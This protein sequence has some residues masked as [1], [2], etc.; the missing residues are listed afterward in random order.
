MEV[1]P[2][3]K[4]RFTRTIN[5]KIGN[6]EQ[7]REEILH[8]FNNTFSIYEELFSVIHDDNAYYIKAEP[9]RHP[10]IFYLGHT[11]TFLI[12]KLILGGYLTERVNP[13][14]ESMFAVGVD[15][16]DWDDLNDCHYEWP[17][18]QEVREYREKVQDIIAQKIKNT[19]LILPI[20][21]DS[22]FW[23]IMMGIEHERIHLETSAVIIRRLPIEYVH[24]EGVFPLC[25][26]RLH[27]G[28]NTKD[29][30]NID[31][32]IFPYNQLKKV[33]GGSVV[34]GKDDSYYGWDN[35][36]GRLEEDLVDFKASVFL[37]TNLEF[38]SFV[39][40]GGY[41][42][43][44]YWTQEGWRWNRSTKTKH[45]VFWVSCTSSSGK[46][47]Y[48]YRA[49]TEIVDMPW[50]W[51][52]ETNY[53]EAKAFCNWKS[54]K[55]GKDIRLP[56]ESEWYQ[57]RD[58]L[59]LSLDQPKWAFGTVG[60][61]NLEQWASSCPV[62]LNGKNGFYDVIGNVW[63]HT[64]THMDGLD[65]F[66][67][68]PLYDDFST[69]TFD[70][71]HNMI[72][73]GSWISTGNEALRSARYAFRRHFYQFAGFRYVEST[74]KIITR[75]QKY[76]TD[77]VVTEYIE[78]H[79]GPQYL[80]VE[81]FPKRCAEVCIEFAKNKGVSLNKAMDVGCAV[82]RSTFEL[83][84]VFDEVIGIDLSSRFFQFGVKVREH[85]KVRYCVPDEGDILDYK[86]FDLARLGLE[87]VKEKVRFYQQDACNLDI[88]K[89]NSFDLIFAGN[90][91][92]RM[93]QPAS[94]LKD[95]HRY[96]NK[97]GL[98]IMTCPYSWD[99]QFTEKKDWVG[100]SKKDGENYTTYKAVKDILSSN[101]K[102]AANPMNIPFVLRE[103]KRKFQYV[104]AEVVF[105]QKIMD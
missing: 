10:L 28:Y 69:P 78:F 23:I 58:F 42:K 1:D 40:E 99:E 80:N 49:F 75:T 43:E 100:A 27:S 56:I 82:G 85:G 91:L 63:Q 21:W 25:P 26:K 52:V 37:V 13:R 29:Q 88:K 89:F 38:I 77:K 95:I 71:Q 96:L 103:T 19:P 46:Q 92:D 48:K 97:G 30:P 55:T 76:E 17:S 64:E 60:N 81:N 73:G 53:L 104:F 14:L 59:Y 6:V 33:N 7:K 2:R 86:E 54:E 31:E 67:I 93:K 45:P 12:N 36:Y 3:T 20:D 98:L 101:F 105:F 41:E 61:I 39:E 79:Y 70:T 22:F 87:N 66:K 74:N 47:S 16:M 65:G 83:A 15:E 51:P 11:A 32:A 68:H 34:L 8:Y 50:D 57:L 94:F 44:H 102:E 9:L 72:K 24:S 90:L 84:K 35:E 5:L 18:V 62:N 4:L